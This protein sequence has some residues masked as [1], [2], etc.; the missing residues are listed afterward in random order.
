MRIYC[1]AWQKRVVGL[2]CGGH[3]MDTKVKHII[4]YQNERQRTPNELLEYLKDKI[5]KGEIDRII[6]IWVD[7]NDECI[8]YAPANLKRDYKKS[9]ILWDVEQW[10]QFFLC[11]DD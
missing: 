2:D 6:T 3:K 11:R 10:K 5:D 4:E 8:S 1:S 9:A 7:P